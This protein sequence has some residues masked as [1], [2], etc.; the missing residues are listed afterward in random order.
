MSMGPDFR[1]LLCL[2][3]RTQLCALTPSW[4]DTLLAFIPSEVYQHRR[5]AEAF[6][7]FASVNSATRT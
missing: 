6:P 2:S 7:S 1:A 5:K 3:V 4:A